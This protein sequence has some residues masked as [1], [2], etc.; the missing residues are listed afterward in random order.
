MAESVRGL[1][2]GEIDI[3]DLMPGSVI[4]I[5]EKNS[6]NEN[7]QKIKTPFYENIID[8]VV[9]GPELISIPTNY[10]FFKLTRKW[11]KPT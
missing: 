11:Y 2:Q 7:G 6:V 10:V 1:Y 9:I 5:G 4:E 3:N 8:G